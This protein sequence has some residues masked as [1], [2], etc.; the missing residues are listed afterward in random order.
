[1]AKAKSS[2]SSKSS[3]CPNFLR[4]LSKM[5]KPQ[6]QTFK[7]SVHL[8]LITPLKRQ[9]Q[10][11]KPSTSSPSPSPFPPKKTLGQAARVPSNEANRIESQ[12]GRQVC[13]ERQRGHQP[14][15]RQHGAGPKAGSARSWLVVLVLSNVH[16]AT[17]S[18]REKNKDSFQ[19]MEVKFHDS[20]VGGSGRGPV[21][22]VEQLSRGGTLRWELFNKKTKR[23]IHIFL[24]GVLVL[25]DSPN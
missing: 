13:G 11:T 24:G 3:K 4:D 22:V 20:R 23:S 19:Q 5:A 25:G 7:Q 21:F 8:L 14:R 1:M 18:P 15:Q 9:N 6:H 17:E 12:P 10:A 2:N 16:L